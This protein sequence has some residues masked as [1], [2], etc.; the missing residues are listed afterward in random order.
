MSLENSSSLK[1]TLMMTYTIYS[2]TMKG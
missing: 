2:E 1:V